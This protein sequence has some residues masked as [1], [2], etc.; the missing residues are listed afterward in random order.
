MIIYD[1]NIGR[2][3]LNFTEHYRAAD[4]GQIM[5]FHCSS[6]KFDAVK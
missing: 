1:I 2:Q 5:Y 4:G 6:L 3:L